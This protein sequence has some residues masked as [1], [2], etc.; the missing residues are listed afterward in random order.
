MMTVADTVEKVNDAFPNG[1]TLNQIKANDANF[2]SLPTA[3]A[4]AASIAKFIIGLYATE[5]SD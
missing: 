2:R 1:P 4:F 3:E 5:S